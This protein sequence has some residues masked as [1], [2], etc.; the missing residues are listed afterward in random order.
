MRIEEGL[1]VGGESCFIIVHG[2]IANLERRKEIE[3]N[4]VLTNAVT[5]ENG[6]DKDTEKNLIPV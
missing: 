5:E 1:P 6:Y 2:V 4:I 3:M